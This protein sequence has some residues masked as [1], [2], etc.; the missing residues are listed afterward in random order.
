MFGTIEE[1]VEL[2]KNGEMI[3]L[4]DNENV[5]NEI[6]FCMAAEFVT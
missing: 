4:A 6:D 1:A 5:E 3:C 2:I